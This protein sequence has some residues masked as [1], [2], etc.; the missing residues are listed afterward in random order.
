MN[1]ALVDRCLYNVRPHWHNAH[2]DAC[3]DAERVEGR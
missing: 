1:S 3:P 2:T